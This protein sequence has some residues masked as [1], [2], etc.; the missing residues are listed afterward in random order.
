LEWTSTIRSA[1]AAVVAHR[2]EA[3]KEVRDCSSA[4]LAQKEVR[5]RLSILAHQ[6]EAPQCHCCHCRAIK[7]KYTSARPP[8]LRINKKHKKKYAAWLLVSRLPWASIRSATATV[9]EPAVSIRSATAAHHRTQRCSSDMI[10]AF[11]RID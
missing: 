2:L 11:S 3:P 4:V 9:V 8:C 10:C 5:S 1:T 7:K 6:L